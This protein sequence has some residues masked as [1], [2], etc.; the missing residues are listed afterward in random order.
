MVVQL[1]NADLCFHGDLVVGFEQVVRV[2]D[3]CLSL[4]GL[5]LSS[6]VVGL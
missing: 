1:A 5:V 2:V 6:M 3:G 4:D